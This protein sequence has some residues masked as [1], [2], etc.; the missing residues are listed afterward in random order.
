LLTLRELAPP[1]VDAELDYEVTFADGDE[2]GENS[3]GSFD[4]LEVDEGD[5]FTVCVTIT[6][7]DRM[8]VGDIRSE[9]TVLIFAV[10]TSSWSM[11][12]PT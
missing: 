2:G 7:V 1:A 6:N 8:P 9:T 11:R 12:P 5:T 3:A 10:A 4:D